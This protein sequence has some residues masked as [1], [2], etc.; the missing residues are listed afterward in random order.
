[1]YDFNNNQIVSKRINN[2]STTQDQT[3]NYNS[4]F[5]QGNGPMKSI[6][7]EI[8]VGVYELQGLVLKAKEMHQRVRQRVQKAIK[9]GEKIELKILK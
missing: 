5:T 2:D 4:Y 3:A 1:M 9:R 7:G 8:S 6:K